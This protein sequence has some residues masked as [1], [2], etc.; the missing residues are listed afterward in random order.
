MSY[1]LGVLV[2]P[3]PRSLNHGAATGDVS[4]QYT[5]AKSTKDKTEV[6][7]KRRHICGTAGAPE[8]DPGSTS[9]SS[10]CVRMP[11]GKTMNKVRNQM[12]P[13]MARPKVN[14]I[15]IIRLAQARQG[16]H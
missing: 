3:A 15:D 12:I 14:P 16:F 8:S 9:F 11:N 4:T 6:I 7:I 5:P 2:T 10:A 1:W 13:Y